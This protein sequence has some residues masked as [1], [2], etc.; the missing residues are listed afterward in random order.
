MLLL[1]PTGLAGR[2]T[3]TIAVTVPQVSL[4]GTLVVEINTTSAP[5]NETFTVGAGAPVVLALPVGPY[6]RISGTGVTLAVLGQTLTGN[7]VITRTTDAA[8]APV[9]RIR[10]TGVTLRLGGTPAA[11]TVSLTQVGTAD[12]I[13]TSAGLAGRVVADIALNV[14][15]VS[16]T[17]TVEVAVNT[18]GA[19]VALIDRTLPAGPYLRIGAT[20]LRLTVLGQVL[21]ADV[22]VE[23]VDHRDGR[24]GR[25][26]RARQRLRRPARHR[27]LPAGRP[28]RRQRPPRR[29]P[30]RDRRLL[31]RQ[32]GPQP[33]RRAA[34]SPVPSSSRSTRPGTGSTENLQVGTASLSIDV[35]AG[36]YVRIAGT[37][38]I[39][40]VGGQTL[41]GDVSVERTL[42]LG[43]DGLVGGTGANL[44]STFVKIA[45]TNVE[46]A[47]GDGT[48]TV[49]S[50]TDGEALVVTNGSGIA[51]S[52]SGTV[53]LRN[54]PGV[55]L[56]G[57]FLVE[58]NTSTTAVDESFT[59][60]GL[61]R[62]LDAARARPAAR[63][64]CCGCAGSTSSWSSATVSRSAPT[65]RSPRSARPSR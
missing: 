21:K 46:L 31:R 50:L 60:G 4:A 54:V 42:S 15:D 12:L 48:R 11:P 5:V 65:S 47:I 41:S 19:S 16:V 24:Q 51:A 23:Q 34:R 27:E 13:L 14:P 6:L 56:S 22:V 26:G 29:L 37:D 44:D 18:T 3:G 25:A 40:E 1:G 17:G 57:T 35:P 58:V 61:V 52:L 55:R 38:I 8:G 64:R 33:R 45:A 39:L 28:R 63:P 20:D 10:A 9:V 53:A 32:P 30:R 49:L 2:I 43:A 59:V 36:P 7:V 62:E